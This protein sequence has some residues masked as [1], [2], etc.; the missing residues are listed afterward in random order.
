MP[1]GIWGAIGAALSQGGRTFGALKADELE[2]KAREE[3]Q[4][5]QQERWQ[6]GH[7]QQRKQFDAQE[8]ER[9]LNRIRQS[10]MDAPEGA[11]FD[12]DQIAE[13]RGA[14]YGHLLNPSVTDHKANVDS[15]LSGLFGN[16]DTTPG[17]AYTSTESATRRLSIQERATQA[18][19]EEQQRARAANQ[20]YRDFLAKNPNATPQQRFQAAQQFGQ[21]FE[22][23][24]P[25]EEQTQWNE[26]E[27]IR[28]ANE[29]ARVN[30][31]NAHRP[32]AP[33]DGQKWLQG[34]N[35]IVDNIRAQ[36]APQIQA[37]ARADA[38]GTNPEAGARLAQLNTQIQAEA[39]KFASELLGPRPGQASA[40]E[41]APAGD[42]TAE[43]I[44]NIDE[45][46]QR[47][48]GDFMQLKK[49]VLENQNQLRSQGI[50]TLAYIREVRN[51]IPRQP[52]EVGGP[53]PPSA[54]NNLI[55]T[56]R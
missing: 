2:R 43:V 30:A 47:F 52:N 33:S 32:P 14:G 15:G 21:R 42:T 18:T 37:L 40:P 8:R 36:Y 12:A 39:E 38:D 3:E 7:D 31:A 26:R 1:E 28:A 35:T 22:G 51:R 20:A 34:Y 45:D 6:A 54:G 16:P 24:S 55:P 49:W 13:A 56:R 25:E 19:A 46:V 4:R 10:I 23:V 29:L 44:A 53:V 27:R 48:G 17:P 50:D 41:E 9:S 11:Q 5:L